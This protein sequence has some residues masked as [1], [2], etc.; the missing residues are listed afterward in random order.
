MQGPLFLPCLTSIKVVRG[1]T[2]YGAILLRNGSNDCRKPRAGLVVIAA[3]PVSDL[4][5]GNAQVSTL[6]GTPGGHGEANGVLHE[7]RRVLR[8][9][10]GDDDL[11]RPALVQ[12]MVQSEGTEKLPP[13]SANQRRR[14]AG[15]NEFPHAPAAVA[16]DTPGV[17]DRVMISGHR[18]CGPADV[19]SNKRNLNIPLARYLSPVQ[20]MVRSERDWDAVSSF[21]EA[22][23]LAKE[24]AA[25]VREQTSS[26]P[27]R[28]ERHSGR[29]G[30]R[31]DLRPPTRPVPTARRVPP[32]PQR[33]RPLHMEPSRADARSGAADNVKGYRGAGSKQEKERGG[34]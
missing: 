9:V 25:R 12:A 20:A 31:D 34:F 18:K 29:R 4:A 13:P 28:R 32:A 14:S 3:V 8:D 5:G 7:L 24:E 2:S 6:R 1:G 15:Q 17:G 21:C 26:R 10:V 19:V 27:S 23:M 16:R 22:V 33:A 30:S 11:S